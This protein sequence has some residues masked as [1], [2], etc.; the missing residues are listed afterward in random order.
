M[1]AL[2]DA[3]LISLKQSPGSCKA[4][5]WSP[6]KKIPG[7]VS[8]VSFRVS[9]VFHLCSRPLRCV[10]GKGTGPCE[11]LVSTNSWCLFWHVPCGSHGS[12]CLSSTSFVVGFELLCVLYVFHV[13]IFH[14][15][16]HNLWCSPELPWLQSIGR[17]EKI[18]NGGFCWWNP[19]LYIYIY[20]DWDP[21]Q[22]L[23]E[24]LKTQMLYLHQ[25]PTIYCNMILSIY[26]W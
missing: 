3:T 26:H 8:V 18:R 25:D 15:M 16:G 4:S 7:V 12:L 17:H 2:R 20:I 23:I 24:M 19:K 21:Y 9:D 1:V 14:I 22:N 6:W 5:H 13:C 11:C 10:T